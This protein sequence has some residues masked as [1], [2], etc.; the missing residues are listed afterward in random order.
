MS[1]QRRFR[2]SCPF[3]HVDKL[4][5]RLR[6][7]HTAPTLFS[8][9][10]AAVAELETT[11]KKATPARKC[12]TKLWGALAVVSCVGGTVVRAPGPFGL[13]TDCPHPL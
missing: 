12:N 3:S 5:L 1:P 9:V 2:D 7:H 13:M 10:M 4:T 11:T 8:I 6:R